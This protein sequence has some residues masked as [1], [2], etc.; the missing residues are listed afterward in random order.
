M[1]YI[2]FSAIALFLACNALA[3]ADGFDYTQEDLSGYNLQ[4]NL[5]ITRDSQYARTGHSVYFY[6]GYLYTERFL[7]GKAQTLGQTS[8]MYVPRIAFPSSFSGFEFGVG[9][10]FSRHVEIQLAY[11][12]TFKEKKSSLYSGAQYNVSS[13]LNAMLAD[14]GFVINPDDQFQVVTRVG[15]MVR[16]FYDTV[17]VGGVPVSGFSTNQT[18]IEPVAGVDLICHFSRHI[19]IQAGALY[20][21]DSHSNF[22]HGEINGLAGL[23]YTL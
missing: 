4:P 13:R 19:A 3:L 16:E 7:S 9:K 14:V 6:G 18:K 8:T 22:S 23:S 2:K 17:A 5:Q 1:R 15:A 20:V 12:Q 21:A 10:E 11:L